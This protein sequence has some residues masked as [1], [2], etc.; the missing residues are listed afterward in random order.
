MKR[1]ITTII[2]LLSTAVANYALS[3]PEAE[4]P[5]RPLNEFPKVI[6]EWK[7]ANEQIIDE[8]SMQIA[9]EMFYV[10]SKIKTH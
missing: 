1:L 10:F 3:R 5:R 7:A 9:S 2:L 4:Q 8:R 6:G